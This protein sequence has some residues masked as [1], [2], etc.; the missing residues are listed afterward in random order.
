MARRPECKYWPSRGSWVDS[1]GKLQRGGYWTTVR[2]KPILLAAGPKDEPHGPTYLAALATFADAMQLDNADR[3]GDHNSCRVVLE[4]YCRDA[5]TRL[6]PS[7]FANVQDVLK[8]FCGSGLV[9]QP[10]SRLTPFAVNAWLAEMRLPRGVEVRYRGGRKRWQTFR[11]GD[12]KVGLAVRVL[13][14][15]FNWA[16]SQKLISV[17]P[18][19]G[20]KAPPCRSRSRDCLVSPD[21]HSLILGRTRD[22][23]RDFIVC[24]EN[25]GCR[26]GELLNATAADW[27]DALGALVYFGDTRRREGETGHK[28][29]GKDKDRRIYFRGDALRIMRQRVR[30]YPSGTLWRATRYPDRPLTIKHIRV[31]FLAL[32]RRIGVAKLTA[33]SYR[34]TFATR[35]LENAGSIDDLAALMGSS[36]A[37]IRKHY[38]HLMDNVDRMGALADRFTE[39]RSENPPRV[40]PFGKVAE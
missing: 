4:L 14:A 18:I 37:V 29:A 5:A 11:W 7:T 1:K 6:K 8:K 3:K 34:H 15:A 32:R 36:A 33:Y 20:L 30:R 9:D 28:T 19:A 25:T 17:N 35:W 27:D 22:Q 13:L 39:A 2:G 31:A 26:P 21:L 16:A 10:V 24:L 12:G 38:A 40:L 23:F